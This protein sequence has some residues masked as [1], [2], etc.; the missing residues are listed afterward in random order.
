M[1]RVVVAKVRESIAG[2]ASLVMEVRIMIAVDWG[3]GVL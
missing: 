1:T 3:V 2:R